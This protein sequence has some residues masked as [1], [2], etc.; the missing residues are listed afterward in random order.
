MNKEEAKILID[1]MEKIGYRFYEPELLYNALCHSSYAHEQKQRGRKDVESN[2][3]LEF[4][5]DAVIDLLLAEYL[6]LEFPEASEGVMAKVKAAIASEEALAQI[7]RD[8]NLGRYMF[9]GRGEEVSSGRKRDSLLADML[10]AVVAAVYI[11]GGL[12]AVK[13]VLLSYFAKYAKEVVEGKI[14][15]DYKTSLQEITQARYRKLPEYVLVN[16][17]GPSHM[18]KFTVE[19]RLSG[20]LIAVGEGPS[21]KEAEKEAA[22]RAIEKLKGD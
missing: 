15:F 9:L 16:E 11:D 8:I 17:K 7:A 2:E 14:V 21:I 5:G 22:R 3:R 13:K 12:T 19:L 6:Y 10:E 4:L 20:K 18:K 1:F